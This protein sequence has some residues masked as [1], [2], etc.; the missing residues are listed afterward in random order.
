MR[1]S[2]PQ[3]DQAKSIYITN[4]RSTIMLH[5]LYRRSFKPIC[6]NIGIHSHIKSVYESINLS[7]YIESYDRESLRSQADQILEYSSSEKIQI[8][9]PDDLSDETIISSLSKV[10]GTYYFSRPFVAE[11]NDA[12]VLKQLGVCTTS[13]HTVILETASSRGDRIQRY[14][15]YHQQFTAKL[16][17]KQLFSSNQAESH[18]I[19][20]AVSFLRIPDPIDKNRSKDGYSHWVQSYLTRLQGLEHYIEETG[21]RPKLIVEKNPPSW[22]LE[23]LEFYGFEDDIVFWDPDEELRIRQLV[24]PSIRRVEQLETDV[25]SSVRYKM[26]SKEACQ[27]LRQR[28]IEQLSNSND[29]SFSKKIFISRSDADRRRAIPQ[30]QVQDK[31]HTKDFQSY[32]L[33]EIDF[34]EQVQLFAEAEKLVA[35]HGAGLV[36]IM[37]AEEC[38]I[39]EII[40]DVY[41][42]TYYLMAKNLDLNYYIIRGESADQSHLPVIHRDIHIGK[43]ILNEFE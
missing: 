14:L 8:T 13:N 24:V 33:T 19:D 18:D 42:P 2:S 23:S 35:V 34:K 32:Q 43:K 29:N 5:R 38:S 31:L 1:P 20:T 21:T 15:Q 4:T 41:K 40:G 28:S 16:L 22:L 7:N 6:Q 10:T 3:K 36:N 12:R 25:K 30:K 11:I 17:W 39:T 37:F 27:W 9:R 26:V